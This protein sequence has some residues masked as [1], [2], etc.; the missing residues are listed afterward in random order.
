MIPFCL[1]HSISLVKNAGVD[2]AFNYKELR[3]E[4]ISRELRKAYL[5]SSSEEEKEIDLY[6]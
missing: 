5:Q 6:F 4:N 3:D 1:K 2:Y